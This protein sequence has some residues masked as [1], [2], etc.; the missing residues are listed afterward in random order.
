MYPLYDLR[1]SRM[2][3]FLGL[4]STIQTQ[5]YDSVE[6][7]EGALEEKTINGIETKFSSLCSFY[8]FFRCVGHKFSFFQILFWS[9]V[10]N[11]NI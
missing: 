10:T 3:F 1:K 6:E 2:Y 11:A 4:E 5:E 9:I 8:F 7:L